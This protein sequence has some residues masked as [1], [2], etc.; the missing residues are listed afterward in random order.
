MGS[1]KEETGKATENTLQPL[2][3]SLSLSLTI[4]LPVLWAGS[5]TPGP[6]THLPTID[7]QYELHVLTTGSVVDLLSSV[8]IL[9]LPL[10]PL[11]PSCP[12]IHPHLARGQGSWLAIPAN[13]PRPH[14][15]CSRLNSRR[16]GPRES[17]TQQMGDGMWVEG[18]GV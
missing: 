17:Y 12:T 9:C 6:H 14:C 3:Q 16:P 1:G 4:S 11:F 13:N 2:T 15:I 10:L 8:E 7:P 18:Y 5:S